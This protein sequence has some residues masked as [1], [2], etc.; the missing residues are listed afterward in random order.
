MRRS[1]SRPAGP[2]SVF[3]VLQARDTAVQIDLDGDDVEADRTV[4]IRVA[5][6]ILRGDGFDLAALLPG[7]CLFGT[8][9]SGPCPGFYFDER[10]QPALAHDQVGLAAAEVVISGHDGPARGAEVADG[11]PL[12]PTAQ[13]MRRVVPV[14]AHPE[15]IATGMGP[16]DECM[17]QR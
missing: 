2:P 9:A 14:S 12:A 8:T 3:K 5:S 15:T 17:G 7:H 1:P 4:S 16:R 11:E 10:E 6:Q 13:H